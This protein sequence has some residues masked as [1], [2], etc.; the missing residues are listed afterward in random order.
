MAI[1]R[2]DSLGYQI[3]LLSRLFDRALES[4]LAMYKVL[5]GQFPALVMLYQNDGLTQADLCQRINVEQPTMANT[6]NRMERDG[7]VQRVGDPDDKRRSL[8]YLTDRAMAFKDDLIE[9]ARQVP[10][11]ALAGLDSA[12]QD[13]LF[14]II[15][16]MINNLR[17][18]KD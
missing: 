4:E 6:L 14:H 1:R 11:Q 9:R 12:D 18:D 10:G 2:Q 16:K 3:G 8:I 17:I 7:L 15:G 13:K 5:P